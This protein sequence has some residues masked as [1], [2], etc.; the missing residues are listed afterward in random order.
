MEK[1]MVVNVLVLTYACPDRP[2]VLHLEVAL[3][4]G[5]R[6]LPPRLLQRHIGFPLRARHLSEEA[7]L[8]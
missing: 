7:V 1:E 6:R 8:S 4:T 2:C 5:G 3:G